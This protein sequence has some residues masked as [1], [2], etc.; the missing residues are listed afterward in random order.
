MDIAHRIDDAVSAGAK[1]IVGGT[2]KGNYLEPTILD[3]VQSDMEIVATEAFGPVISLIRVHAVGDMIQLINQSIYGLQA[4]V[5]TSDE[6]T[7]IRIAQQLE[8]GSVWI[9]GK[10]QRGPDHFPF[11]GIKGSGVGVQGI[12]YTLE[13]MTRLRPIIMNKPE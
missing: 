11:L 10:P 9:N 6:G 3:M 4:S 5:F 1:I 12:R 13:S 7:A 2:R 8:V